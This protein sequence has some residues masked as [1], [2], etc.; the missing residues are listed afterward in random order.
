MP[1]RTAGPGPSFS[2]S[3]PR[4]VDETPPWSGLR[5]ACRMWPSSC[6]S[7]PMTSAAAALGVHRHRDLPVPGHLQPARVLQ[8]VLPPYQDCRPVRALGQRQ[9]LGVVVVNPFQVLALVEQVHVHALVAEA[10]AREQVVASLSHLQ[11]LPGVVTHAGQMDGFPVVYQL[12]QVGQH[13]AQFL[14]RVGRRRGLGHGAADPAQRDLVH[15]VVLVGL[16]HQVVWVDNHPQRVLACGDPGLAAES[17][18]VRRPPEGVGHHGILEVK[19]VRQN[20]V[21]VQVDGKGHAGRHNALVVNDHVHVWGHVRGQRAVAEG[22]QLVRHDDWAIPVQPPSG[23]Q[24]WQ[25]KGL[26][27]EARRWRRARRHRRDGAPAPRELLLD[28]VV[29]LVRLVDEVRSVHLQAA[30]CVRPASG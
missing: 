17:V 10:L 29:G 22:S 23:H 27:D 25:R 18:P 11:D 19:G 21:E 15:V 30:A 1:A 26:G 9:P 20:S 14:L 24:V 16:S 13:Q 8:H 4:E 6:I 12:L 3:G 28:G 5:S 7:E 2:A